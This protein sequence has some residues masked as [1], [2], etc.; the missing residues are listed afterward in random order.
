MS[1]KEEIQQKLEDVIQSVN[2]GIGCIAELMQKALDN[3]EL[4]EYRQLKKV[5]DMLNAIL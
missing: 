1:K 3:K 2:I 5:Y 4:N